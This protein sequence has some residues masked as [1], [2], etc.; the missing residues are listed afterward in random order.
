MAQRK[1]ASSRQDN[2]NIRPDTVF[3][4]T[5]SLFNGNLFSVY[6]FSIAE[7]QRCLQYNL[8]YKM[9]TGF[10]YRTKFIH[11]TTDDVLLFHQPCQRFCFLSSSVLFCFIHMHGTSNS[12]DFIENHYIPIC[13]WNVVYTTSLILV[14]GCYSECNAYSDY[15]ANL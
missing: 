3:H 15:R 6:V 8:Y 7:R 5:F 9:N 2:G 10:Y 14:A 11:R 1:S 13:K 12:V 4:L